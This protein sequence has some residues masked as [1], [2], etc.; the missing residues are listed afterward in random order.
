MLR[1]LAPK[2]LNDL[3]SADY[4]QTLYLHTQYYAN[5]GC[6]TYAS[7]AGLYFFL[8]FTFLQDFT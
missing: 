4:G 6:K 3:K 5:K 8:F 1:A 2:T 7:F